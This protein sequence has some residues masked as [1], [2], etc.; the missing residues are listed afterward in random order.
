MVETKSFK[1][2]LKKAFSS[3]FSIIFSWPFNIKKTQNFGARAKQ[4]E[5]DQSLGQAAVFE[6]NRLISK[7][8]YHELNFLE[9]HWSFEIH[10]PE[11]CKK[12]LSIGKRR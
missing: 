5:E 12:M 4:T 1:E 7:A 3:F 9:A 8:Q 11:L 6:F 2:L 10:I